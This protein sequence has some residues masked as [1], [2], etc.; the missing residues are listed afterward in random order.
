[1]TSVDTSLPETTHIG[2]VAMQVND[3]DRLVRFY[4]DV[5]GLTVLNRERE[6]ATLGTPNQALLELYSNPEIPE[7]TQVET[8]LFHTAIRVPSRTALGDTLRR[9][10]EQWRLDG[11]SDHLVSEAIY[12]TDPEGNGVEVYHDRPKEAWPIADDGTVGMKTQPLDIDEIGDRKLGTPSV[13]PETTI[14]HVH[15]EVSSLAAARE[16]Y[17]DILG[18]R[19][20]QRFGSDALFVAA[21]DYHHHVGLNVWNGRTEPPAGRG[22]GW[23]E[24]VVPERETLD[25]VRH[26]LDEHEIEISG[27]DDEIEVTDPDGIE[28][29]LRVAD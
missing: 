8:G 17:V 28:L 16:F 21:G 3:L 23:F 1:M 2:R 10:R 18:L 14:G 7:R 6:R 4:R 13:P 20:R 26:R 22:L 27:N 24:L 12:F 19:L 9:V 25:S 29:R 11:A 15:L 5:V